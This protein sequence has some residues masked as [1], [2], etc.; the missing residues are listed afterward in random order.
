MARPSLAADLLV[1]HTIGQQRLRR[2]ITQTELA[3]AAGVSL[4]A[5]QAW[6][7]GREPVP[8]VR[9]PALAAALALS[10]AALDVSDVEPV[11]AEERA[12]LALYRCLPAR[13]RARISRFARRPTRREVAH[14][15]A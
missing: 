14:A 9:K 13:V 10:V 2:E 8:A 5:L 1:G 3:Q 11:T 7:A 6:E 15:D 12:V 4:R